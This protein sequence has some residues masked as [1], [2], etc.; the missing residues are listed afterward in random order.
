ME[1]A[2]HGGQ[3]M[4]ESGIGPGEIHQEFS[5]FWQPRRDAQHALA[6]FALGQIAVIEVELNEDGSIGVLANR[7]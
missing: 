1:F 3:A 6:G 4:I 5:S 2:I 7:G